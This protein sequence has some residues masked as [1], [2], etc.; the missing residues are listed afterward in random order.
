MP[1]RLSYMTEGDRLALGG[2]SYPLERCY[3]CGDDMPLAVG[4]YDGADFLCSEC[5]SDHAKG[6]QPECVAQGI[7]SPVTNWMQILSV[8]G[9]FA[10]W[11]S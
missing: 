8:P 2:A 6:R 1:N 11:H 3:E 4:L 9:G 7:L 5:F 10:I